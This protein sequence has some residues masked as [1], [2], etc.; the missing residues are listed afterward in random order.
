MINHARTLLLNTPA[1]K[2]RRDAVSYEYIPPAFHPLQLSGPLAA[3]RAALFGTTPDNYFLNFRARELL[4]Y[5]HETDLAQYIYA[6]D[7]RVTYWPEYDA[8]DFTATKQVT[9]TQ[10]AGQP[11]RIAVAGRFDVSNASGRAARQ[12]TVTLAPGNTTLFTT[13]ITELNTAPAVPV[14]TTFNDLSTAPAIDVPQT[15]LKLRFS[16]TGVGTLVPDAAIITEV[17]DIIV[18]EDYNSTAAIELEGAAGGAEPA[19]FSAARW[20]LDVRAR[21][22][23]AITTILPILELLGEPN[24]L[25]LFGAAPSEPYTTFKNLWF[26]HPLPAYKL[27]GFVLAF[28]YRCNEIYENTNA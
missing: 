27:S 4:R 17:G 25:A 24:V 6:L 18:V 8:T 15:N 10:T 14:T 16:N 7:K 23:A 28:I 1:K 21:P 19:Q 13:T 11:R 20:S 2:A 12:Y 3:I 26:D 9:L 5:I 22:P